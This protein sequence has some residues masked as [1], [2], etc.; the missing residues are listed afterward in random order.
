VGNKIY[1]GTVSSQTRVPQQNEAKYDW[2]GDE[3]EMDEGLVKPDLVDPDLDS[4][5]PGVSFDNESNHPGDLPTE[6]DKEVANAAHAAANANL[7][8]DN[9][10]GITGVDLP[11]PPAATDNEDNVEDDNDGIIKMGVVQPTAQDM[12]QLGEGNEFEITNT[13]LEGADNNDSDND[14]EVGDDE[15]DED[16]GDKDDD[17]DFD[18]DEEVT[19]RYPKRKRVAKEA[20]VIDFANKAYN[21]TRHYSHQSCCF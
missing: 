17:S 20:T 7:T 1:Q 16:E 8:L 12:Q 9:G 18:D 10:A 5:T 19:R 15:Q 13:H 4:N 21:A 2:D 3:A 11:T 14:G 6:T